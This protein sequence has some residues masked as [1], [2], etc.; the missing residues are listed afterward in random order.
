MLRV[1]DAAAGRRNQEVTTLGTDGLRIW[2]QLY[3]IEIY[4]VQNV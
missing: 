1:W 2:I 4:P 3:S